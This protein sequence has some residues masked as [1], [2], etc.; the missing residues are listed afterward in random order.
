MSLESSQDNGVTW[1]ELWETTS[2]QGN[3]WLPIEINLSDYIGETVQLRFNRYTGSNNEA[4]KADIAIDDISLVTADTQAPTAPTLS[5]SNIME[6]TADLSWTGATDNIGIVAYNLY[7]QGTFV[8]TETNPSSSNVNGLTENTLYDAFT[9][10]A[11]D[12][13]GNE[14]PFSN[15][16]SFT[17]LGGNNC[18]EEITSFP[19]NESFENSL[20]AWTQ[21]TDDDVDWLLGTN[22]TPSSGTGPSSATDGN[23]YLYVEAS[24]NVNPPGTPNKQAILES[25]CLDLASL[26]NPL[27]SFK[28]HMNGGSDMGSI[29][30]EISNDNGINWSSIWHESSNQGNNWLDVNIDLSAYAGENIKLRFNRYTGSNNEAWKADIAI[31]KLS[32]DDGNS[33]QNCAE[34]NLS[35]SITFDNFPE[36]TAWTIKNSNGSTVASNSYSASNPDGSTINETIN[37]LNSG[38]N[39]TFTIT[40]SYGDGICCSEGNGS[41]ELSS[42]NGVIISGGDFGS[43]ET[44]DFCVNSTRNTTLGVAKSQNN[45][46]NFSIYPNPANQ[47]IYVKTLDIKQFHY[48][49]FDIHGKLIK[50]N[51][52]DSEKEINISSLSSGMY[53]LQINNKQ[54]IHSIKFIKE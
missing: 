16:V 51:Y 28:Y 47:F 8:G 39:Y 52:T 12:A 48:K 50:Q 44:I 30:L 25:P 3:Q 18:I 40:D 5:V 31:D 1:T 36:E 35:L 29:I 15:E 45:S 13:A 26:S 7:F 38:D 43:S 27:F 37:D 19:Y 20:G 6:T 21:S 46:L 14:S 10:T 23:Y 2:N 49:I 9:L 24:S 54:S 4:W 17:T 32:L 42:S 33:N 53:F 41:Y 34:P 22:G 11:V